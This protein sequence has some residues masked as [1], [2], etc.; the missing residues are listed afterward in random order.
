MIKAMAIAPDGQRTY[1]IGL[2]FGNLRKFLAEPGD[3]YIRIPRAESGL[4]VDI[5]LIS[6][7]TEAHIVRSLQAGM[8]PN[9]RI[10]PGE[11]PDT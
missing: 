7:E 4:D 8:D 3:T 11:D 10:I 6:G 1:L 2:S 9:T 5:M